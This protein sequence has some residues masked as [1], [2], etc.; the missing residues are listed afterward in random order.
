M[1]LV[2]AKRAGLTGMLLLLVSTV[3]C[4]KDPKDTGADESEPPA[5]EAEPEP[6]EPEV[7]SDPTCTA[8]PPPVVDDGH[9]VVCV[10]LDGEP[11]PATVVMQGG[12]HEPAHTDDDG[13]ALV[14]IKGL[15]D[16][17]NTVVASHPE[18][19]IKA[20]S[21][22]PSYD[23]ETLHIV[24]KR[25]SRA[26][27]LR[28][29]FQD[30]GAPGDSPS[31]AQCGHCHLSQTESW[32]SSVHRGSV[33]NP[34]VQQLYAGTTYSFDNEQACEQAGGKWLVGL[35]PGTTTTAP[36]CYLGHGTLPALN[37]NCGDTH[38]CDTEATAFGGCADCHAPG[39]NGVVGGRDL[40]DATGIAF[41]DGV[42][43]DTCH[44]VESVNLDAVEAGV[45]GKLNILRPSE[46]AITSSFGEFSP[47]MFGPRHDVPNPRMGSVQRDHFGNGQLCAGCHEYDQPVLVSGGSIDVGRWPEQRLPVHSTWSEWEQGPLGPDVSCEQCHMPPNSGAANS[48]D[49][50]GYENAYEGSTF[51]FLR[52]PGTVRHHKWLGR[53]RQAHGCSARGSAGIEKEMVEGE[54]HASVT[55]KHVGPGHALPT[56]EPMRSMVLT[57]EARCGED[58]LR[59]SGGMSFLTLGLRRYALA[60]WRRMLGQTPRWEMCF[61]LS[62]RAALTTTTVA[63]GLSEMANST[64]PKRGCPKS[65]GWVQPR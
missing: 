46:P 16:Q 33:S 48:I 10:T 11:S 21:V 17:T 43:C 22:L 18:A 47:L 26:D 32:Y 9:V 37:E 45:A 59:P 23:G 62:E 64:P 52:V 31:T 30:P 6:P 12:A 58:A 55:V 44:R 53:V 63:L 49:V 19:R 2:I 25:F 24:L 50:E 20:L 14:P 15:R 56:G 29:T 27:N 8:P 38:S 41:E 28:Y 40:L 42:H 39:I 3:A 36:R 51:G 13:Y 61:G 54:V 65:Y 57:V 60:I 35:I 7:D 4:Q 1:K 34:W 5:V